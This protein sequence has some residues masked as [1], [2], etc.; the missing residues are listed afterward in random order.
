[1]STDAILFF[2]LIAYFIIGWIFVFIFESYRIDCFSEEDVP[3]CSIHTPWIINET[4]SML[5]DPL[6]HFTCLW[7]IYVIYYL[8]Y[9]LYKL[10]HKLIRKIKCKIYLLHKNKQK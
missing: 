10:I 9:F 6:M 8:I 7:P 5:N 2:G 3:G 1:M 4:Y